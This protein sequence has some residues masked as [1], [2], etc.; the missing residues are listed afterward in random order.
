MYFLSKFDKC[1]SSLTGDKK[2]ITRVTWSS[3]N[4]VTT[5]CSGVP[6]EILLRRCICT[7]NLMSMSLNN[8]RYKYSQTGHLA[9][10]GLVKDDGQFTVGQVNDDCYSANLVKS[11]MAI[12]LFWTVLNNLWQSLCI[13]FQTVGYFVGMCV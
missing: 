12:L 7:S 2:K 8:W 4:D 13:T 5:S 11:K 10:L 3:G 9:H 1:S 6:Y